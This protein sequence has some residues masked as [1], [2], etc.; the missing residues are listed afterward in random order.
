MFPRLL[1]KGSALPTGSECSDCSSP[2]EDFGRDL[3]CSCQ[4]QDQ[5][6]SSFVDVG[7]DVDVE[8]YYF[9]FNFWTITCVVA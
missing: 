6:A 4:Q 5:G 9:E 2:K 7:D 1:K 8:L 3:S